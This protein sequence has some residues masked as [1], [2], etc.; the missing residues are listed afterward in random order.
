MRLRSSLR[1]SKNLAFQ[2]SHPFEQLAVR[3]SK[4]HSLFTQLAQLDQGQLLLHAMHQQLCSPSYQHRPGQPGCQHYHREGRPPLVDEKCQ[5]R[6]FLERLLS[7]ETTH[8]VATPSAR[9][10][11][12]RWLGFPPEQD[13]WEPRSSL[14]RD[15]PNVLREYESVHTLC[16]DLFDELSVL[17]VSENKTNDYCVV[18]KRHHD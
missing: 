1:V 8:I 9:K 10:Y 3:L 7:H 16:S 11:R 18:V 17:A 6:W 12:V 15:V 5:K 13:T 4:S 2:V 14:L